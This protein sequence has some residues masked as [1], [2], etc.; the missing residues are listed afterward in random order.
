MFQAVSLIYP[1][2]LA[3]SLWERGCSV[4]VL[5]TNFHVLEYVSGRFLDLSP[6]P[7]P[8]PE[9]EGMLCLCTGDKLSC[10]GS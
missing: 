8:L 10:P 5:V 9:G 1:L 6:L 2:S 7:G 4:C 3:L